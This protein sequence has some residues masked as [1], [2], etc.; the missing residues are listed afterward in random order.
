MIILKLIFDGE[1]MQPER[2]LTEKEKETVT[3]TLFGAEYVTYYQGD[4]PKPETEI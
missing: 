3:S 4:E 2:Q 1:A